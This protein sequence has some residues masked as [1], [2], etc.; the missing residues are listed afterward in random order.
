MFIEVNFRKSK[1]LLFGTY[2][3]QNPVYGMNDVDYFEQLGL[4]LD[5]YSGYDKFLLAGDFNIEEEDGNK[6]E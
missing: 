1:I 5:V 3:S 2:H 4:A 6:F